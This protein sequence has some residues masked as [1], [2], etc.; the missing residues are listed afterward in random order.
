M[1]W[2]II[3]DG[4]P[5]AFRSGSL[6]DIMPTFNRL[7]EKQPNAEL[8]WFQNGQL[9][10]SRHDAQDFM[11]ARGERG[12]AKDPRQTDVAS[13]F[14][15]TEKPER[16]W[17]AKP[18]WKTRSSF[19]PK[20]DKPARPAPSWGEGEDRPAGQARS[21]RKPEWKP[22]GTFK[23]KEAGHASGWGEKPAFA[24]A[25][26]GQARGGGSKPAWKPKGK[27][28]ASGFSRSREEKPAWKG[29]GDASGKPEWKPK[30]TFRPAEEGHRPSARDQ[31]RSSFRP[32]SFTPTV[33]DGRTRASR[34]QSRNDKL[35]WKPA[36][37]KASAGQAPRSRPDGPNSGFA[38][39]DPDAPKRKWVPKADYKKSLGIEAKRDDKWRPGGEHKDPKQKYKDA[40]K[41]KW[42]KFKANIRA[43][44]T[45]PRK[46]KDE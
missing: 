45:K 5:T 25:S 46:P 9:W 16:P 27:D 13:G 24:K 3:V 17:N 8:K 4:Q 19:K 28:V 7:K 29:K 20:G 2:T 26:A 15:R 31:A 35:E 11:R 40:K 43:R 44:S 6:E 34:V 22:K 30:G 10:P 38:K 33:D 23:P 21:D 36:S 42:T 37:A 12:R 1:Y 41:A 18:E 39:S 32:T 14:S